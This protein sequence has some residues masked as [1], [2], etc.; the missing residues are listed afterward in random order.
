M[1]LETYQK[2]RDFG[3]TPE[4]KGDVQVQIG[5]HEV[6][7]T[8][9]DKVYW[10]E[11]GYTK[12]DLLK[13]YYAIAD[14]IL[15][16]LQDRPLIL[17]RHPNGIAGHSFFQHNVEDPP[18]FLRTVAQ[19]VEGET[20]HYAVCDNLA[21]L[22]YLVNLGNIAQNPWHSC[23]RDPD[24]PNWIVFDLD[25][26]ATQFDA[27]CEVALAVQSMLRRLGLGAYPKTSGSAGLHVYVPLH[28]GE[29]YD[30]AARFAERVAQ[31][32]QHERPDI[33]TLERAVRK[34]AARRVY[35]DYLQ[36]ARGKSVVSPY[37]VRA[38]PGA[39]VSAPLTWREVE[40][41]PALGDFTMRN[42]PQRIKR[43]KDLFAGV[44]TAGKDQPSLTVP[45]ERAEELWKEARRKK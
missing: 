20:V 23:A 18:Q 26:E 27:A 25:A 36:N 42:M 19:D 40:A 9:L 43:K 6:A 41:C 17:K 33:V 10:P 28:P 7:L 14:T 38:R 13:Y 15:P 45:S 35:L 39:T 11:E 22:L 12:G 4:P 44:L 24:Q 32:V 1:G 2:K 30:E 8:H 34:R 16:Y 5:K 29:N 3:A 31:L 37:S 21:S